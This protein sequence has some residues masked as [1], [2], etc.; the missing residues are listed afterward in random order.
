MILGGA[1]THILEL[2]RELAHQGH[3]VAVASKGGELVSMLRESGIAH[4][5]A[6]LSSHTPADMF[7][8]YMRLKKIISDFK[9][10]VVH[11]HARIPAF[12]CALI[13]RKNKR[14]PLV[15]TVH[16]E[17]STAFPYKLLTSWG[18]FALAVSEDLKKYL[19]DSYMYPQERIKVTMNGINVSVFKAGDRNDACRLCGINPN[20]FNIVCVTRL[21][22][23]ASVPAKT[24][25]SDALHLSQAIPNMNIVIIGGG[26]EEGFLRT[27]ANR[28]NARAGRK[29]VHILGGRKNIEKYLPAADLFVGVSR[30]AL[31]AM[32][33]EIP[34]VLGGN[35]GV[36]G[37]LTPEKIKEALETNLT[38]R[39]AAP[40]SISSSIL[41]AIRLPKGYMK[42]LGTWGRSVVIKKYSAA[43]MAQDAVSVYEKAILMNHRV[44]D[45]V[46]AGYYGYGNSG[47]E[48]NLRAIV[49]NL[50]NMRP[51]MNIAI[52]NRDVG[53]QYDCNLINR[54]NLPS[55]FME[56]RKSKL[57]I[58]G[59][60]NILQDVTSKK[61]LWYYLTI[62]RMAKLLG[63]R[64]ML[65]A[66]GIGSI[67]NESS[68]KRTSA[69]LKNVDRITLRDQSSLKVLSEMGISPAV[70]TV[71]ADEIFTCR[72][73]TTP[74]VAKM[75]EK[76][77]DRREVIC[78]SLREWKENDD[79]IST[80]AASLDM[81]CQK[82]GLSLLFIP[83]QL[84]NDLAAARSVSSLC[85]APHDIL[86]E[87]LSAGEMFALLKNAA[88][89]VGMRYHSLVYSACALTPFY[90]ISYEP[91][92]SELCQ[93]ILP[94]CCMELEDF[95]SKKFVYEC[96]VLLDH[97]KDIMPIIEEKV[98]F[99]R[100]L[101]AKNARIATELL[102][103]AR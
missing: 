68:L 79:F 56:L 44:H 28:T 76:Y 92:V 45:V 87:K 102:E 54:F 30:A 40:E 70:C 38:C 51:D 72:E 61:S 85:S 20:D 95:D 57:L 2:S 29:L 86:T 27:E 103:D 91:K 82:Y 64:T 62:L 58:F 83:M 8:A 67:N 75:R 52:L 32:S 90:G 55:V 12:L 98:S 80:F 88:L 35:A 42:S 23:D 74:R 39:N 84:P 41:E 47:D 16:G 33:C 60:G 71:T 3:T 43:I 6:P 11:A 14:P 63:K 18:D 4:Y 5:D 7:K 25:V 81:L 59:G 100:A 1:E 93:T 24:L 53:E 9:P 78:V 101:A 34:V 10:D 15:T 66:N 49:T 22:P 21:D 31:E 36:L 89:T 77:F 13:L 46:I 94:G 73:N 96:N 50:R 19:V 97:R 69:V 99:M 48:E 65:Y 26:S 37:L 17:Y